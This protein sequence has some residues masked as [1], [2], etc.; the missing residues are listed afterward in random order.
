MEQLEQIPDLNAAL[1][2]N[3][4]ATFFMRVAGESMKGSGIFPDD[5]LLIDRSL[6]PKSGDI[7]IAAVDGEFTVKRLWLENGRV[8]LHAENPDYP[9]IILTG[10]TELDI[11]GVVKYAI[12]S[13]C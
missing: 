5:I 7:V 6:T 2:R 10:D 8:E 13:Y 11:W 4:A 1:M 12:R 9:P 3:P